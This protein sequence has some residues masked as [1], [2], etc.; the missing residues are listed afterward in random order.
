[1]Q[2]AI[3][4]KDRYI[5]KLKELNIDL[6]KKLDE[7]NNLIKNVTNS[8]SK[9][10]SKLITLLN[11]GVNGEKID[12]KETAKEMQVSQYKSIVDQLW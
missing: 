6:T 11:A 2:R 12:L 1:M 10:K 8:E 4:S 9:L 7:N 3:E 5:K